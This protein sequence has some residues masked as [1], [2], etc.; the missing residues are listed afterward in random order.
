MHPD[1]TNQKIQ[2]GFAIVIWQKDP[3]CERRTVEGQDIYD[4]YLVERE[5]FPSRQLH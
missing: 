2:V 3:L 1:R 5:N 4:Q